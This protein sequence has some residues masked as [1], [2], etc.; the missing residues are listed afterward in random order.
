MSKFGS[1]EYA[2][3]VQ[4]LL[5][6]FGSTVL[7]PLIT[8]LSPA[9][10]L[11]AA[12]LGTLVFHLCTKGIVPVFLGSSFA[13]IAGLCTIIAGN[14]ANIPNA[15]CGIIAAGVVYL[16]L[17]AVTYC[18]GPKR[19]KTFFPVIVT[20]PVIIIIGLSL[21][22][23]GIKDSFGFNSGVQGFGKEA[24]INVIIAIITFLIV[25]FGMNRKRGFYQLV[26]VLIGIVI[27]Y[28]CCVLLWA[29]K[30]Y[31]LDFTPVKNAPW[32]N[33]PFR[34]GFCTL[35]RWD[36][37]AILLLAPISFVTFMEHLGDITT[38]GAVVGQDFFQNPGVH[39]TLLGDGLATIVAGC[40]GGPAN[41]TYSENTG[42]L[43][44]TKNYNPAVL[45]LAAIFAIILGL[46]GKFGA[47]LQTI[48]APVKGG[49]E[50]VLFGMIAAIGVRTIVDARL[51]MTSSRNLSIMAAVLCVGLGLGSLPQ[52]G[53]PL[54][55]GKY[56]FILS[57]LFVSM[58]VGVI[59]NLILPK[60]QPAPAT[61]TAPAKK[62]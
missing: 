33:I 30:Q 51:D 28:L 20:G 44:T 58:L 24:C 2:L 13:F 61:D 36:L 48:P 23:V 39:R 34:N 50:M 41:T 9:V 19:I 6:M 22:G 32:L 59:M 62:D 57:P 16:L 29:C 38:N 8:G 12:G 5:A 1:R 3:G 27:G 43:A 56:T 52:G 26:P 11:L 47:L 7:V 54:A 35:P 31:Q 15:Q 10:A 45:R 17:A 37:N 40:I 60:D 4:H 21:A 25:V 55:F 46:C 49:V 18:T 42:V 14:P 53:I